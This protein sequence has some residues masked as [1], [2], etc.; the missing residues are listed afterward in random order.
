MHYALNMT[1]C[2]QAPGHKNQTMTKRMSLFH[3]MA[4]FFAWHND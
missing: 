2:H 1:Y 3:R 4:Y